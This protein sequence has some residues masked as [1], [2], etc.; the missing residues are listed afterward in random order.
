MSDVKFSQWQGAPKLVDLDK[1]R[2][3]GAFYV[4]EMR[5]RT[6]AKWWVTIV[7]NGFG[8][9]VI[10]LLAIGIGV[11][12]LVD[13]NGGAGAL[14]GF[15]YLQFLA[16]ALLASA[17]MQ[18]AMDETAFPTL[19]GFVWDK[20][21]FALNATR[22][23]GRQIAEGVLMGA[24]VRVILSIFFYE[25]V[26]LAFSA[27]PLNMALPLFFSSFF[28][29]LAWGSLILALSSNVVDDDGFISLI[30]RFVVMPMFLFSGT[31]YPLE[32]MP[33]Y[34]QWIG[35]ISPLWHATSL[36]RIM[37]LELSVEP[38]VWIMHLGFLAL[39]AIIGRAIA[40]PTFERRLSK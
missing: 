11:G 10:Y 30:F 32:Q 4:A 39:L 14:G 40:F 16:P 26:L 1:L 29:G 25:L 34:L 19:R 20:G 31:F 13:A 24:Y 28:A 35:W 2:W 6:M 3:F 17:A 8:N 21:F 37:S 18:S 23:T 38:W 12:T 36:G 27:I 5:I 15:S 33:I 22:L 7:L 9:P